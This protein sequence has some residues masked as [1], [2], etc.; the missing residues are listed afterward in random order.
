MLEVVNTNL[1]NFSQH[2]HVRQLENVEFHTTDL[3]VAA[4]ITQK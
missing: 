1:I 2:C 3:F 4:C